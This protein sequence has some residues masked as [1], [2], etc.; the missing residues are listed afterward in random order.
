MGLGRVRTG[1]TSCFHPSWSHCGHAQGHWRVG[2]KESQG[3]L[4][5]EGWLVPRDVTQHSRHCFQTASLQNPFAG[6]LRGEQGGGKLLTVRAATP[7]LMLASSPGAFPHHPSPSAGAVMQPKT[8]PTDNRGP[9][10]GQNSVGRLHHTT[11]PSLWGRSPAGPGDPQ[12]GGA[13]AVESWASLAAEG[14]AAGHPTA[15]P[16][17]GQNIHS[18]RVQAP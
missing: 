5:A 8:D 7:A 4:E 3:D 18:Q 6:C 12:T 10:T 2:G 11:P 9:F 13:P 15:P 14:A 16:F 17:P 1:R